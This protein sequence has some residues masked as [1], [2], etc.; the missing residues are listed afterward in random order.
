MSL[1]NT[2]VLY[3]ACMDRFDS[4]LSQ[5]QHIILLQDSAALQGL[6]YSLYFLLMH[7]QPVS[8]GQQMLVRKEPPTYW[9]IRVSSL[10]L[11]MSIHVDTSWQGEKHAT[12]GK[13]SI[14]C[15]ISRKQRRFSLFLWVC[16][17]IC[18]NQLLAFTLSFVLWLNLSSARKTI[19]RCSFAQSTDLIKS[20]SSQICDWEWAALPVMS[21]N[22]HSFSEHSSLW[23]NV[24]S[25]LL[26]IYYTTNI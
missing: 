18:C 22:W 9:K 4:A 11:W 2:Y 6:V 10:A 1:K 19:S 7:L 8:F 17:P 3:M 21:F 20:Y 26:T 24:L 14:S 25:V 13:A 15:Y 12:H 23:Y 5:A 16:H